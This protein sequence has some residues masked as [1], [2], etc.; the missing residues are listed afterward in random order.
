MRSGAIAR[1][2]LDALTGQL[3]A[4]FDRAALAIKQGAAAEDQMR[5]I[6]ALIGGLKE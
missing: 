6:E 5:V 3:G 1:L 4:M 2:P